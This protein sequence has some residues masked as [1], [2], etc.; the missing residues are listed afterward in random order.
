MMG[1]QDKEIL[2]KGMNQVRLIWMALF[3]LLAVYIV[4]CHLMSGKYQAAAG[5]DFPLEKLRTILYFVAIG[6]FAIT[7]FLRRVMLKTDASGSVLRIVKQRHP[8]N[9]QKTIATYGRTVIISAAISESI[10][11]YGL[12]LFLLGDTFQTFSLFIGASA[13]A[14]IVYRPKTG[15]LEKMVTGS[16]VPVSY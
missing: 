1:Q 10:G 12:V 11:I 9:L 2:I 15:E 8:Q 14:M 4:I 5:P 7:Y 16:T 3:G 13:I 6:T